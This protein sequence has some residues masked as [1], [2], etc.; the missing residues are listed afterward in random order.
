MFFGSKLFRVLS[1][2]GWLTQHPS[3]PLHAAPLTPCI[4]ASEKQCDIHQLDYRDKKSE[5]LNAHPDYDTAADAF[6]HNKNDSLDK[7]H[8]AEPVNQNTNNSNSNRPMVGETRLQ[9]DE[10]DDGYLKPDSHPPKRATNQN[11]DGE[12]YIAVY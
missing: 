9:V 3:N 2:I 4:H 1:L 5:K 6:E 11:A 7:Y 12:D 8:T 10:T